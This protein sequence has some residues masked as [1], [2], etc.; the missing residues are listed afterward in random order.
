MGQ[1]TSQLTPQNNNNNNKRSMQLEFMKQQPN[2]PSDR[3]RKKERGKR[4]GK[5]IKKNPLVLLK[6]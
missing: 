2:W 6:F 5:F 3:E 4:K 1:T